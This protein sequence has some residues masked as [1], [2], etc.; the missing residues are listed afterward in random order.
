MNYKT[1]SVSILLATTLAGCGFFGQIAERGAEGSD[2]VLRDAIWVMCK[3][4]PVGA[5]KRRFSTETQ[6]DAYN[7]ICAEQEKLPSPPV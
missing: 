2:E 5:V 7:A 4:V 3:A 6:V 1:L